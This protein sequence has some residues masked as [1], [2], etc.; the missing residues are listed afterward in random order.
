[1]QSS[2]AIT[3]Y[4]ENSLS[5]SLSSIHIS[6]LRFFLDLCLVGSFAFEMISQ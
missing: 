1:M 6:I 3:E 2:V 5:L 4:N